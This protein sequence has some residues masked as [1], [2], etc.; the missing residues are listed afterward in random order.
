MLKGMLGYKEKLL[1]QEKKAFCLK[2]VNYLF[3]I[4]LQEKPR[5]SVKK[6]VKI[7]RPGY[8]GI[9]ICLC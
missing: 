4:F 9:R 2:F 1:F 8:K 3:I 7:G 6:F 5:V